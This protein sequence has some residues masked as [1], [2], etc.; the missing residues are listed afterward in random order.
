MPIVLFVCT[1]NIIRSPIASALFARKL[2][3]EGLREGWQT[4]S[5]GTWARDG[6]PAARESQEIL[7]KMGIDLSRHRSRVVNETLLQRADLVLVMEKGHKEALWAEFPSYKDRVYLLSEMIGLQ[8]DVHDPVG[9]TYAD[10]EETVRDL[11]EIIDQG[12]LKIVA[13]ATKST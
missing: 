12:F 13:L 2:L 7:G 6:Y 3:A 5:A 8:A 1:A 11:Q 10:F 9:G 4:A